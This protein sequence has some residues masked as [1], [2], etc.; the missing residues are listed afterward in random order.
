M[1][2]YPAPDGRFLQIAGFKYSFDRALTPRVQ[3]VTLLEGSK[4]IPST[5]QTE[6]VVVTNDFT[7]GGGDGYDM[8]KETNPSASRD[9]M[10]DLFVTFIK[11]TMT[12]DPSTYPPN[13]RV[14]NLNP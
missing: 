2:K 12:L 4:V 1:A 8:L 13:T 3:S 14:V 7:N 9:V 6:Y 5:D 10:V 11:K